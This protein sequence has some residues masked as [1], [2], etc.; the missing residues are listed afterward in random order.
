MVASRRLHAVFV[1]AVALLV[2]P[3]LASAATADFRVLFDIDNNA[4]TGCNEGPAHGV[5]QILVTRI[6]STETSAQVT[7]TYRQVCTGGVF[8]APVDLDL[9]ARPAG[10]NAPSG[11]LL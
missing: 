7:R 4:A 11:L 6:N 2:V 9:T 5:E 8:G 10:F 1:F 3:T